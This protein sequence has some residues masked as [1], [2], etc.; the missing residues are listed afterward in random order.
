MTLNR[1]KIINDHPV[2]APQLVVHMYVQRFTSSYIFQ[3]WIRIIYSPQRNFS[4]VTKIVVKKT[5]KKL[6]QTIKVG[7]FAIQSC[8]FNIIT[9]FWK[10]YCK[11]PTWLGLN[12]KWQELFGNCCIISEYLKFIDKK[13]LQ[14]FWDTCDCQNSL[15]MNQHFAESLWYLRQG[16]HALYTYLLPKQ[17]KNLQYNLCQWTNINSHK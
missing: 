9:I 14:S 8:L 5:W 3:T 1:A 6:H 10:L 17:R 11:N 15:V 13:V 4:T 12:D 7:Y 2:N 16:I